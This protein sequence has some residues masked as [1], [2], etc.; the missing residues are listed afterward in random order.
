M[1]STTGHYDQTLL[2]EAPAATRKQL[3]EGYTTDLLDPNLGKVTPPPSASRADPERG[4][5]AKEYPHEPHAAPA[6]VPFWR[7][8]KGKI[9]IAIAALVVVGAVI[10]GAVGGTRKKKNPDIGDG[11]QETG[12]LPATSPDTGTKPEGVNSGVSIE[13]A[14]LASGLDSGS[15]LE[16][17]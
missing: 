11:D 8:T 16:L 17:E 1:P 7:T 6:A 14:V 12:R 3:Q 15:E 13:G 2:A 9:I 4:L 5:A 10:G